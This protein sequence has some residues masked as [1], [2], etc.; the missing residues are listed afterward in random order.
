MGKQMQ[1]ELRALEGQIDHLSDMVD[2]AIRESMRCLLERDVEGARLVME[3]DKR[4][5]ELRFEIEQRC[6]TLIST[7]QPVARDTREI[8]SILYIIVELERMGDYAEGVGRITCDL[9]AGFSLKKYEE[10]KNLLQTMTEYAI[11]MLEKSMTAFFARNVEESKE[12]CEEDNKV[13][14]LYRQAYSLIL[15]AKDENP[16][17]LTRLSW[18]AHNVERIADRTTNIAERTVFLV[19]GKMEEIGSSKY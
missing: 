5:N 6:V 18:A 17:I 16:E 15:A 12:V 3:G 10:L 2:A 8:V 19:T 1:R 4:I 11:I 14:A 13:D 7:Q 9:P